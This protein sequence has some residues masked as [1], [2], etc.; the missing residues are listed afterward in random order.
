MTASNSPAQV[1]LEPTDGIEVTVVTAE[2]CHFCSDATSLLDDL[3]GSYSI[4]VRRVDLL[5]A[6][7]S[8]IAARFR[9][10]F[11]P[12]VL[13]DGQYFGHGRISRRKL[14]KALAEAGSQGESP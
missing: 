5:D 4:S 3:S 14:T 11:P 10:P 7:G 1:P 2:R 8:A 6:E 9:V 13:I 12:V